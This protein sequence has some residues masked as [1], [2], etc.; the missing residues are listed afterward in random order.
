MMVDEVRSRTMRAVRSKDTKP[1]LTVRR[2]I[3]SLGF[4]FRLHR[5]DLP[6]S[7]DLVFP[8]RKKVIFVHGCFWHGHDCARGAR[9]P[10]SNGDYWINKVARNRERDQQ[11]ERLLSDAGWQI[12]VVWE[13]ELKDAEALRRKLSSFL[14]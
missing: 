5:K 12:C 2:L 11:T 13:C 9:K 1:E 7:P 3:H 6:G 14:A 4:R 8:G 10:K